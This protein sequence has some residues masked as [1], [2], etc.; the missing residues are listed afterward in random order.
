MWEIRPAVS[1]QDAWHAVLTER[2]SVTLVTT[3]RRLAAA[4]RQR[5][6]IEVVG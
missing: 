6:E 5:C 2:P 1:V 4:K 3:D